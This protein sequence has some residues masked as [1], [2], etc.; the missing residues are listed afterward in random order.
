[1]IDHWNFVNILDLKNGLFGVNNKIGGPFLLVVYCQD[2]EPGGL[3][4][5]I[6]SKGQE[7]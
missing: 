1:M 4:L 2:Q 6:F 3:T 7:V 5:S